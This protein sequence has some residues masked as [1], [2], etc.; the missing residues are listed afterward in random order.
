MKQNRDV[1]IGILLRVENSKI[2]GF[3]CKVKVHSKSYYCGLLSYSKPILSQE[4]RETVLISRQD[5]GNIVETQK[6][7]TPQSGHSRARDV[8]V[9]GETEFN[10]GYQDT[11]G[12]GV[13]CQGV[14]TMLDGSIHTGIVTHSIYQVRVTPENFRRRGADVGIIK[15]RVT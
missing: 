2:I 9:P 14:A 4:K 7:S 5:C 8:S 13:H 15:P 11:S 3:K 1:E 10:S 12:N 6:F